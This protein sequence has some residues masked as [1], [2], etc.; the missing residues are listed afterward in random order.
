[1][2]YSYEGI[3]SLYEVA[4]SKNVLLKEIGKV[5]SK[6][7]K[8]LLTTKVEVIRV[9]FIRDNITIPNKQLIKQATEFFSED[10]AFSE[11]I[12]IS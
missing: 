1:M 4:R 11:V 7:N 9:D 6:K 10:Y 5:R 8:N 2:T 12:E 3:K